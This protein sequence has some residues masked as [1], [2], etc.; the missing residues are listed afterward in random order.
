M[1]L[2]LTLSLTNV[3]TYIIFYVSATIVGSLEQW[4]G[5][6]GTGPILKIK[7]KFSR[8]L[9]M[10]GGVREVVYVPISHLPFPFFFNVSSLV[11]LVRGRGRGTVATPLFVYMFSSVEM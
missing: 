5:G 6:R 7:L 8:V 10:G 1:S 2:F 4:V 3:N 9:I 11:G